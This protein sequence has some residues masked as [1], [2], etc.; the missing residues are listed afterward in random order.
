MQYRNISL[1][2]S[3]RCVLFK[4]ETVFGGVRS[5]GGDLEG[6]SGAVHPKI[7]GGVDGGA[8]APPKE[9]QIFNKI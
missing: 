1:C 7:L 9:S 3:G 5:R 4:Q 8:F 6:D 2:Y